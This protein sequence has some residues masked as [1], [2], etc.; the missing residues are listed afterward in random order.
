M[1]WGTPEVERCWVDRP[2]PAAGCSPRPPRSLGAGGSSPAGQAPGRLPQAEQAASPVLAAGPPVR[3]TRVSR[4]DRGQVAFICACVSLSLHSHGDALR[5]FPR[6]R[7][8]PQ[9]PDRPGRRGVPSG[10][11]SPSERWTPRIRRPDVRAPETRG[12]GRAGDFAS[13]VGSETY[14]T[15]LL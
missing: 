5:T 12:G 11:H 8:D 9:T 10:S 14:L 7:L 15:G 13:G 6:D 2:E 3:T 1:T 4:G